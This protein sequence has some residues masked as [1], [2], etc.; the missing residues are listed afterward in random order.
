VVVP[1]VRWGERADHVIIVLDT[2]AVMS[3]PRCSELAWQVLVQAREAWGL[4]VVVPE[5]VVLE[6]VA[7]YQRSLQ[8]SLVGLDRWLEKQSA[9]GLGHFALG[10]HEQIAEQAHEYSAYLLSL[11]KEMGLEIA[12]VPDVAH[13]E[14]VEREWRRLPGHPQLA[15]GGRFGDRRGWSGCL[16]DRKHE[17]LRVPGR[18]PPA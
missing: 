5:V 11:F 14:L 4:R 7:G 1:K 18:A 9:L 2:T 12:A 15:C 3:D 10:L 13:R 8:G 17:G 6:A 16:G